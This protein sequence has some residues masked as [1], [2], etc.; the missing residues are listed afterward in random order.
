MLF[1]T[2]VIISCSSLWFAMYMLYIGKDPGIY[3][4]IMTG[5][6]GCWLPNPTIPKQNDKNCNIQNTSDI[7]QPLLNS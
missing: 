4:P 2:Q 7:E 6:I 3:L 1:P 5:I